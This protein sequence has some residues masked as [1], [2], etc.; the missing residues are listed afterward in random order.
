[1]RIRFRIGT[2]L[3]GACLCAPYSA[4]AQWVNY[5]TPGA[6]RTHDG[7]VNLAAP[8]PR[9]ANGKPDLSGL[10]QVEPTPLDEMTRL[11]GD[12]AALSVPGDDP[13]MVSKY[14]FNILA[15]F[16]PG[17]APMR[18]E[19]GELVGKRAQSGGS[20]IPTS[21]C[22]PGGIPF[23]S[24][25]PFPAKFIQTPGLLVMLFEADNTVRQVYTD[26][27]KYPD[28]PQPLWLGYSVGKWEGDTLVVD[29][30]GF[31]DKS[32]LDGF[33]HPHSEALHVTERFQRRDF[34][35]MDVQ[36]T[37]DDPKVYT[38]PFTIKVTQHLLPDTDIL[39]NFCAENEKDL[40]HF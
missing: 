34:G 3:A 8:A 12:I 26:G 18:P 33:G 1:M 38:K 29:T 24:F 11:F 20:D 21:R 30:V 7:K 5:P 14:L 23:T 35:H 25:L 17:E 9:A 40:R 13:R 39:E 2:M 27:R 16:K 37:L 31:N 4:N 10:W 19:F 6:P 28:D 15:D 32:W 22:L 36:V